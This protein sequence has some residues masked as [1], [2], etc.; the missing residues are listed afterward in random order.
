MGRRKP[1]VKKPSKKK[2]VKPGAKVLQM[3]NKSDELQEIFIRANYTFID[4]IDKPSMKIQ[5]I[6]LDHLPKLHIF[7]SYLICKKVDET[8]ILKRREGRD[9]KAEADMWAKNFMVTISS[10]NPGPAYST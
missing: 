10:L 8:L 2:V 6:Y 1:R 3:I 9:L 5:N 4:L 7:Y